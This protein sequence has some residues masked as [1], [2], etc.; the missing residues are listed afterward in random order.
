MGEPPFLPPEGPP[1]DARSARGF[2]DTAIPDGGSSGDS[3]GASQ[4]VLDKLEALLGRLR[5]P[6]SP[7]EHP[8]AQPEIPTLDQPVHWM[9][10]EASPVAVPAGRHIPTLDQRVELRGAQPP[11]P[12][13]EAVPEAVPEPVP[14]PLTEPL[15]EPLPE[16]VPAPPVAYGPT[17]PPGRPP[18]P[19]EP[20]TRQA[21]RER[22]ESLLDPALE[23]RLCQR[24]LA[25]L[26]RTLIDA[27]R[28]FRDELAVW[29]ADQ[30][31]RIRDEVRGE[32]ERAVDEVLAALARERGAGQP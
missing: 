22:I 8:L 19:P 14:E 24:A 20:T 10:P 31:E 27:E 5:G 28:A 23:D 4:E 12:L 32:I 1:R 2:D 21:L 15:T 6:D 11:A 16:P 25:D 9:S 13:P 29:R 3:G 17:V 7:A 26:D 18:L 30:S